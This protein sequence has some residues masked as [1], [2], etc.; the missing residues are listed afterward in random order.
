MRNFVTNLLLAVSSVLLTYILLEAAYR[1]SLYWRLSRGQLEAG[2][3]IIDGP[4]L[5]LDE[6][7]GFR[8]LPN[9][10]RRVQKIGDEGR[11]LFQNRIR[12]NNAGHVSLED[13]TIARAPGQFRIAVIGDSFAAS[14]QQNVPW[15]WLLQRHLNAD[16]AALRAVGA[17]SFKV[18]NFGLEATGPVQ[19][20]D[21][22]TREI[23]RY[24]PDLV[25]VNF[26]SDDV[27]RTFMWESTV[28]PGWGRSDYQ[29]M[30]LCSDLPAVLSNVNC[31]PSRSIIVPRALR[32]DK[33]E[34]ASITRAV[35]R[36]GARHMNWFT[37]YPTLLARAL[38]YRFGL[39]PL[40]IVSNRSFASVRYFHDDST[41]VD[42]GAVALRRIAARSPRALLLHNPVYQELMSDSIEPI[43]L[44][45]SEKSGMEMVSMSPVMSAG[46]DP[47]Q[48]VHWFNLPHDL[49]FN[50]R[51]GEIYARSVHQVLRERL[52]QP[53]AESAGAPA[54]AS[55]PARP[56]T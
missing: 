41:A 44:R 14:V 23:A 40:Q 7:L 48:I 39:K 10:D 24:R 5:A 34:I 22:Y 4:L 28:T 31:W 47:S 56:R 18:L 13:D 49:H 32:D 9:S 3:W 27:R 38:N 17:R 50:D 1:L 43:A 37:P 16:T 25:L 52:L 54:T 15:P 6:D 45:L 35:Y 21:I 36:Y 42:S 55:L 29:I 12:V 46:V 26:I 11:V 8:Y 53:G 30:L 20:D 33:A 2:A 19:W 51:G